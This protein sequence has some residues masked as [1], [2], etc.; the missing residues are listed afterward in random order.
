M[1]DF[2]LRVKVHFKFS[3]EEV[4]TFFITSIISAFI[5][6]FRKWG[7]V[8]FDPIQ[9]VTN[10]LLSF[11]FVV[12]FLFIH[13]SAQK[14]LAIKLGYLAT[15]TYWLNGLFIGLILAFVTYGFVPVLFTGS[16]IVD[17]IPRLRLGRFRYGLNYKDLAKI[18]FAGPF[19][20]IILLA[21]LKP[22]YVWQG[23]SAGFHN[24]VY[25]LIWINI[26]LAVFAM[27]P[28]KNTSGLNI[29]VSSR[30]VY[31]YCFVFVIGYSLLVL[32]AGTFS[33]ILSAVLAG[34][35]AIIYTTI[36]EKP[37]K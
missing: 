26:L 35:L 16:V 17:T 25:D 3:K 8:T 30:I 4:R 31:V 37:D 13:I 24:F 33:L 34:I 15:Y 29:I 19:A 5:I 22:F 20:N 6:S 28:F 27:L 18:S 12:L 36:V 32:A 2:L 21:L 10:L 9:G 11:V 7:A 23:A 1:G 14:L